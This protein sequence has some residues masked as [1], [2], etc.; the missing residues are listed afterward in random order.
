MYFRKLW[1]N[2]TAKEH[3]IFIISAICHN[4]I[5][6][7]QCIYLNILFLIYCY[8]SQRSVL[9]LFEKLMTIFILNTIYYL[10]GTAST[11][12][13]FKSFILTLILNIADRQRNDRPINISIFEGPSS[14]GVTI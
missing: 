7:S 3:L 5:Y 4:F 10:R 1:L 13:Q 6:F 9:T 14:I 12:A 11:S 2:I 8:T